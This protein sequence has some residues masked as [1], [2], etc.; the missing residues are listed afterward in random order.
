MKDLPQDPRYS[1]DRRDAR[2]EWYLNFRPVL[3]RDLVQWKEKHKDSEDC[4]GKLSLYRPDARK[5]N[6]EVPC[7]DDS[8]IPFEL[9]AVYEGEDNEKRIP[10]N[11]KVVEKKKG[12][13]LALTMSDLMGELDALWFRWQDSERETHYLSHDAGDCDLDQG[14]PEYCLESSDEEDDDG[15]EDG[16]RRER[17]GT[18]M[19]RE[20]HLEQCIRNASE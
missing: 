11:Q 14:F 13:N 10:Q 7:S 18:R 19:T 15:D 17:M 4:W 3:L 2:G 12:E 6:W 1:F 16:C 8:G 9:E 20:E 5:I